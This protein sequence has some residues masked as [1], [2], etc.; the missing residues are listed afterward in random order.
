MT[1]REGCNDCGEEWN[2]A[3]G[4]VG[5]TQIAAPPTECPKCKSK[6]IHKVADAWKMDDG[7]FFPR[8][9]VEDST[10][11]VGRELVW[12]QSTDKPCILYFV[13]DLSPRFKTYADSYFIFTDPEEAIEKVREICKE[14]PAIA[15]FYGDHGT[16]TLA[17]FEP[18]ML[19]PGI[20]HLFR[21]DSLEVVIIAVP[22]TGSLK[23]ATKSS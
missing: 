10:D 19:R 4:I 8:Q 22:L 7:S 16:E 20:R 18:A 17:T 13:E 12:V 2:A 6:N 5:M 23:W 9:G 11:A 15:S 21:S 3:F 14:E 1:F